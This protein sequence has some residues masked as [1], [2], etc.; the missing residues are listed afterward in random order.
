MR[1]Y[2]YMFVASLLCSTT[3][4]MLNSNLCSTIGKD[5]LGDGIIRYNEIN[6]VGKRVIVLRQER[7][8]AEYFQ[9]Y[10]DSIF[11]TWSKKLSDTTAKAEWYKLRD[12]CEELIKMNEDVKNCMKNQQPIIQEK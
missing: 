11:G 2:S 12:I 4:A 10:I 1:I 9:G 5:D 3:L 6:K 7:D 8:G